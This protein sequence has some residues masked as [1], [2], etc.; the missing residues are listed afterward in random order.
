MLQTTADCQP[1]AHEGP[2][3]PVTAHIQPPALSPP[4]PAA[5][6]FSFQAT[7]APSPASSTAP[8]Q[9]KIADGPF[10]RGNSVRLP[11]GI[12]NY[13]LEGPD[14]P[15]PLVVCIHGLNGSVD[16]FSNF[17]PLL[18][19]AGFRT[20]T[21]DLYG[22]GLSASPFGRLDNNTYVEQVH[23]LLGAIGVPSEEKVLLLGFS[24]GG[25]IA[26]EFVHRFPEKVK[27]LLLV[28]PGGLLQRSQ[29]PCRPLLFGCLRGRCGCGLLYFATLLACC[30]SCFMKR[31][32]TPE[33][34]ADR[35]QIDVREPD[36]YR[37]LSQQ[38]G[39]RC[40]WNLSRSVN[41]Y[42]R[43]LK[44][45]PLWE[46]DFED[47]YAELSAKKIPLL[48]LWGD[49]DGT[50][51]WS[52]V[53]NKVK[54]LFGTKGVSCIQIPGGCH[55]MLTEDAVPVANYAAAFF[56]D[57]RD[58]AWKQCLEMWRLPAMHGST[59]SDVAAV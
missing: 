41:S 19:K 22:F 58:P 17:Q 47:A 13:I 20:L 36:K 25:V 33:K 59:G 53:E 54:Q 27:R 7:A 35:F 34:L 56:H 39:E 52:E 24:M 38:N 48:F 15:A 6:P 21:F 57:L 44:R 4:S 2:H 50:I 42:L 11:K 37:D 49:N 5:S 29:T 23:G 30:C 43:A 45:M 55:G 12:V 31:R 40:L 51:P 16:T 32:F 14:Y 28:A 46:E 18:C 26:V 8:K 3:L 10:V 9:Q 1:Q